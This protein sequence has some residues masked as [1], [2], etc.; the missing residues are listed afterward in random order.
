MEEIIIKRRPKPAQAKTFEMLTVFVVAK[1]DSMQQ[2]YVPDITKNEMV[3]Q[4]IDTMFERL[5]YNSN[6]KSFLFARVDFGCNVEVAFWPTFLTDIVAHNKYPTRIQDGASVADALETAYHIAAAF[7]KQ[8]DSGVG[9][10]RI[11]RIVLLTDGQ[12]DD[13]DKTM[14]ITKEWEE[15][16]GCS[17]WIYYLPSEANPKEAKEGYEYCKSLGQTEMLFDKSEQLI[18]LCLFS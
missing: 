17:L 18:H 8:S 4:A 7:C 12:D 3:E 6:F 5:K 15:E 9:V 10:H 2:Q 1:S 13:K 16:R 11:S 14:K